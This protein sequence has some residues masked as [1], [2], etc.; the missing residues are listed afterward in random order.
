[1]RRKITTAI[2]GVCAVVLLLV[3]IPLA[4]AIHV[5]ILDHQV[6]EVTTE[7]IRLA[8]STRV[9]PSFENVTT[10]VTKRSLA[11]EFSV[12]DASGARLAGWGPPSADVI[13]LAAL[14]G[15]NAHS[16]DREIVVATP[17]FDATH[18]MPVGAVRVTRS[19]TG[20]RKDET[21]AWLGLLVV[22]A[23]ALGV[24]LL[25][26]RRQARVLS[27]PVVELAEALRRFSPG[28]PLGDLPT[29]GI[30]EF[31]LLAQALAEGANRVAESLGRERQFSANVS[32][33]LRTPLT[34]L[35][36][37]IETA[38]RSMSAPSL[39]AALA[40]LDHVDETVDFLLANA[41]QA[42]AAN[43]ETCLERTAQE[44]VARL[45]EQ[46]ASHGRTLDLHTDGPLTVSGCSVAIDQIVDI[47]V[48]NALEH[49]TGAVSISVRTLL[50]GGVLEVADE[51]NELT[52]SDVTRIFGRGEGRNHGMGLAI[53]RSLAEVNGGRLNV[54]GRSP[55]TFSLHLVQPNDESSGTRPSPL[56]T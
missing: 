15:V 6:H 31:S 23:G 38:E 40:D 34:R 45:Q 46:V 55:T 27:Q 12:Y 41:R 11:D 30:A 44:A 19:F 47:L 33:Q 9:A 20:T 3:G 25:I 49:G 35:R 26:A 8:S 13:T 50:G 17:I 18:E 54:T 29:G 53:A 56:S 16:T 32:H 36:L 22:C 5:L 39:R 48:D 28:V 42:E 52:E 43:D 2:V 1:M 4:F 10:F 7:S 24:G 21:V 51:G 14:Q 37:R